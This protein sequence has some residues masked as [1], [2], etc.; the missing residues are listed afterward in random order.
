MHLIERAA[1]H[2]IF[3]PQQ[4]WLDLKA[5]PDF[6]YVLYSPPTSNSQMF[7]STKRNGREENT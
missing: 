3:M 4:N 6:V 1:A 7:N 2:K 5:F